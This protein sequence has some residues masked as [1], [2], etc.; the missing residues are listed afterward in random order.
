MR[1]ALTIGASNIVAIGGFRIIDADGHVTEPASLYR[2][3]IEPEF[4]RRAEELLTHA[5]AGNLGIIPALVPDWRSAER[6]LGDVDEVPG[7]GKLPS[8]R[9]HPLA[10]PAGGY[11]PVERVRDMDK[12]GIDV[13]VCFATVATSVCAATDAEFEAAL[14]RAYNRWVGEYCSANLAR[15]RAVG[16]VPQRSM[17]L[18]AAEVKW[19]AREPWCV[20]IMTFGN[21]DGRL[22]DH[23]YFDPLYRAA[24]D[25]GMPICFHGGTDR[26]PFAPGRADVGNNM[27]MMHLTGHA[28]H[29]MRAMASVVGG[30]L[31]ERYPLLRFGFFEGGIS[32]VPW[33]AERM[34]GHY[35]H[36]A[37]HTPHLLRKPSEQMRGERCFFTFDPDEDLLPEALAMLGAGRLM[38]ASDYP[39]F[40]ARFPDAAEI[41]VKHARLTEAHKR[42]VL[43]E[44]ALRFYPRLTS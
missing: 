4:C 42:A 24:Q 7:L 35:E 1:R 26:P 36:F 3:H 37:R 8:G 40:D 41:I 31:L 34:D 27:F 13:A 39:H 25:E 43:S 12:E 17:D 44:N 32:W 28:W 30:G 15:I 38:W 21:L 11:D 22:A 2:T 29:Q 14:A 19:L 9:N 10:S 5:G 33:W 6:P 18:C 20:G 16:I 23:P